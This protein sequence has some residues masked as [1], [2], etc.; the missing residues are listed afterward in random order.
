MSPSDPSVTSVAKPCCRMKSCS[1]GT[2]SSLKCGGRYVAGRSD[3]RDLEV[4]AL[5]GQLH[6]DAERLAQLV[7]AERG[8]D[9]DADRPRRP[10]VDGEHLRRR[11]HHAALTR[12]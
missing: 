9:A 7:A 3:D 6:E 5:V 2:R 8:G 12:L 1:T 11:D 4:G 10:V